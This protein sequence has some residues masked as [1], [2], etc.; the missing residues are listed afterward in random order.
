MN[1]TEAQF[2]LS[3]PSSRPLPDPGAK[4]LRADAARNRAKILEAARGAFAEAGP[5][6]QMDDIARR[7]GVGVGTVYRHFPTKQSLAVAMVEQRFATVIAFVRDEMLPDPDPWRAL[8]RSFEFCA[9]TQLADRGYA[10]LVASVAG[11]NSAEA[12]APPWP[13]SDQQQELLALSAQVLRRAHAAGLVRSDLQATDM[14]PLYA[15]LASV[16]R[17]GVTDWRRYVELLLDGL[18]PR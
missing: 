8:V 10:E 3:T 18:R 4:P 7:A 1:D 17:A 9:A 16:V 14:P 2:R 5:Q 6:A 12:G 11:S 13:G 15:G